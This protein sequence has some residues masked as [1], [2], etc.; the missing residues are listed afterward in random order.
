M[1]RKQR[2]QANQARSGRKR[3]R[4]AKALRKALADSGHLQSRRAVPDPSDV[5]YLE[6]YENAPIAYLTLDPYGI[7]LDAN[8]KS[9][10]LLGC[11]RRELLGMPLMRMIAERDRHAF[12]RHMLQCRAS[13][14]GTA[15]LALQ[16]GEREIAVALDSCRMTAG[17]DGGPRYRTALLDRSE[18]RSIEEA[19][20]AA[21]WQRRRADANERAAADSNHAKDR[22]LAELSHEMRTPLTPIL[23]AVK[24]L[25]ASND[26]PSLLRPTIDVI[27]RNVAV[28]ARLIDDLLD[29]SRIAH[30]RL[31]IA[32]QP[33]DAHELVREMAAEVAGEIERRG[34]RFVLR[35]NAREARLRADPLRLRQIVWNLVFNAFDSTAR[36]GRVEIA[37]SNIGDD[38]RVVVRDDGVGIEPDELKTIFTAFSVQDSSPRRRHEGLGLGLAIVKGLVEAHGGRIT[39]LS[40]G[41]GL[42]A[43]FVVELPTATPSHEAPGRPVNAKNALEKAPT[44]RRKR[45]LLVEDHADTRDALKIFLELK[46]YDVIVAGDVASALEA[47]GEPL[48][49]VVCDLGLPDGSGLDVVQRISTEQPIKA[50]ALSGY[51]SP[52]DF[53]RSSRAGFAAHLVKPVGADDLVRTIEAVCNGESAG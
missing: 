6:F 25:E 52:R 24:T 9:A 7:V 3:A 4:R 22:F 30:R 29:V 40:D 8:A 2:A 13:N 12:L 32:P 23:A 15:E 48:D 35:L 16:V 39:A 19:K 10:T 14:S 43:R 51:G 18:Q 49:V 50:I 5:Y 33:I 38:L 36:G 47:A 17:D 28:E 45:V 20:D 41:K 53:E 37:S 1:R 42:G 27:S 44:D 11:Q 31:R 34:I 21:N 46:G 26:V